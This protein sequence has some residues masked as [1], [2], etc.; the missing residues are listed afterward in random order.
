MIKRLLIFTAA[1][2]VSQFVLI[3][4]AIPQL[5]SEINPQFLKNKWDARWINYPNDS[6]KEFGVYLFRKTFDLESNP[7]HFVIHV[8]GDN[9]YRLFV[10]G[11]F[12]INGPARGDEMNWRFE[13]IDIGRFLHSGLNII[14]AIVWN[15]GDLRPIAQHSVRTGLIIQGD[16]P[17]DS[18]V[19]TNSNWSV[20]K[21]EA[22]TITKFSY[23]D[24]LGYFAVG[25]GENF[26]GNLHPW[27]WEKVTFDESNWAMARDFGPGV[28]KEG[29]YKHGEIS[30]HLLIPRL[31]PFME[32]TPQQFGR[33]RTGGLGSD[34]Q[35]IL[36]ENGSFTVPPNTE[37]SILLDQNHLTTAFP[38]LKI[39]GG[40]NSRI[41]LT[42]AE[43]MRDSNNV[44]GNRDDIVGKVIIGY[45]DLFIA[46]GGSNRILQS[47]WWRTF[48]Y[49]EM[50]IVTSNEP[51]IIHSINSIFTA[52]PLQEKASFTSSDESLSD[53]WDVGWRTQRL[54]AG[55][56]FFDCPYYEQL[57]YVGD[58]RIQA[59]VA[60]YVSGDSRLFRKA[61]TDFNDSRLAFGLTQSRYPSYFKQIIPPYSLFWIA[62]VHDYWMLVNDGELIKTMIP[63]IMDVL[64]WYEERIDT[65]GMLGPMEWWNFVDWVQFEGWESGIPAGAETGNSSIIS[66]QLVY[67]LYLAADLFKSYSMPDLAYRYQSL[68]DNI[69]ASVYK[70]CWDEGSQMLADTPE[71]I[72]FS[73]HANITGILVDAIPTNIQEDLLK[74][75]MEDQ[76][77]ARSSYYFTFY[78]IRALNKVGLADEYLATLEPW[79][80]MLRLGLTTFAERQE[81]TRSDCHAWSASPLYEFLS[82]VTGINPGSPA[83]QTVRI[84][85]HLGDMTEINAKMP[86]YLGEIQ[87]ALKK[88]EDNRLAGEVTLPE[89]LVGTFRW[90]STIIE[91]MGGKNEIDLH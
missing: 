72:N 45:H 75:V 78:L 1:L 84:E 62:M 69:K 64:H 25:P 86:H 21:D 18:V 57:Q 26:D 2:F 77:I 40:H 59:L 38:R 19:N 80:H 58:T 48:R 63:G 39:S 24:V 88:D 7:A 54:C 85:P 70:L 76:D 10:N 71:K 79:R 82:T 28:P 90:G 46:D 60:Y 31:I 56:T 74:R 33:I 65:T 32:E 35:N 36:V 83:F 34:V 52:Y 49:V 15:F 44:K 9:R 51:L 17:I 61:I 6:G 22:Y 20:F 55:E 30:G 43:S 37:L 27:G 14:C 12:V 13:T 42:F 5:N 91:L 41:K 11:Q 67:N 89:G 87:V 73:Q 47:L 53:I 16:S 68:G 8:S 66:L 4:E 3:F 50:K 81:P 23:S 29:S